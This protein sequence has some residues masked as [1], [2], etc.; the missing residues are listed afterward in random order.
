MLLVSLWST[1]THVR[2]SAPP[3]EEGTPQN[4][5]SLPGSGPGEVGLRG[6]GT[7]PTAS[8]S[9]V[10]TFLPNDHCDQENEECLA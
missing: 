6:P 4:P 10:L 8:L 5:G 1:V 9:A 2:G 3:S 7:S